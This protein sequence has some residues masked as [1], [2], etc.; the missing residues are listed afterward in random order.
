MVKIIRRIEVIRKLILKEVDRLMGWW[1][2]RL[3]G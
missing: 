2:D 3:M 1:V